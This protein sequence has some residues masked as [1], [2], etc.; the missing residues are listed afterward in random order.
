MSREETFDAVVL[1]TGQAGKPLA[2]A[3]ARAGRRVA[4]VER[5]DQRARR[6]L[7]P[8]VQAGGAVG[9]LQPV[10]VEPH[11]VVLV[12]HAGRCDARSGHRRASLDSLAT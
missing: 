8:R 10:L 3:L 11:P 7:H 12:D 5:D 2:V 1:G 9:T 6:L 4:V